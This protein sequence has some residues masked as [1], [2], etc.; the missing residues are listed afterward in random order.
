M[1]SP[2]RSLTVTTEEFWTVPQG[3]YEVTVEVQDPGKA[4]GSGGEYRRK[5]IAVQPGQR[6]RIGDLS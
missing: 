4:N 2:K 6:L 1:T 3:V 5:T